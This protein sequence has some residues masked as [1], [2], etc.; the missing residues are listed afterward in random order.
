MNPKKTFI[1]TMALLVATFVI[2][3]TP[4]FAQV[5]TAWVRRYNGSTN[6]WD[7]GGQD[8]VVD[9]NGN[10]YVT[11]GSEEGDVPYQDITTV[12]YK[13]NGD[14]SWIRYYYRPDPGWIDNE[15][16]DIVLGGK[17]NI[18]ITGCTWLGGTNSDIVT[19][20]YD[21]TGDT[22][23]SSLYA[24]GEF[25]HGRAI[26]VDTNNNIYVTGYSSGNQI[27]IK[28]DSSG[29][30]LAEDSYNPT[31][32]SAS[33]VALVVDEGGN[34]YTAG[35]SGYKYLSYMTVVKYNP[36]L[37]RL[38]ARL[39]GGT[40]HQPIGANDLDL[41]SAGNVYVTG[42]GEYWCATVKYSPDGDSIWSRVIEAAY[43]AYPAIAVDRNGNVY[44]TVARGYSDYQTTKYNTDGDSLWTQYYD[45][46]GNS[47]DTPTDITVDEGGNVY[48][49][50]A[51][52]GI[53]TY[54]DIATIK[55]S[56][57]GNPIWIHRYNGRGNDY[58]GAEAIALDDSGYVYV[59]GA[60]I[61]LGT[62]SDIVTIKYIQT[63]GLFSPNGGEGWQAGHQYPITWSSGGFTGNV[64]IDYSVNSG[65]SFDSLIVSSCPNTGEYLWTLPSRT[66]SSHCRVRVCDSLDYNPV[67]SSDS[68]FTIWIC[69]DAN[70][71]GKVNVNDV[72]YLINYLFVPGSP[73]PPWPKKRADVNGDNKV[74]VND[75]VYL[76]NWLFVPGSPPPVCPGVPF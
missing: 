62:S 69:G 16:D 12:K 75:V 38:W 18:Y 49:T 20:G 73:A 46:P 72:V 66:S 47:F 28:Y 5:D 1:V 22:L 37:D 6:G 58:D 54:S 13:R 53:D 65:A 76:I 68:D 56:T 15:V 31:T 21:S 2:S 26:A 35:F 24:G 43:Q 50:G 67:D 74:N 29:S 40:F 70:N 14:T 45:G 63:H 3:L 30:L 39:Y 8:I 64:R 19:I 57:D 4:A 25:D 36:S 34:I 55:Y 27:T 52:Y 41:D 44:V 9:E 60:S 11:G 23:W 10:V 17:G 32:Y 33:G 71:D 48:V 59:T 7:R 61:G 51:S 42:G